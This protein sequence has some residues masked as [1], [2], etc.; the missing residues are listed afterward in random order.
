MLSRMGLEANLPYT[1]NSNSSIYTEF[2]INCAY[3]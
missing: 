1:L 3:A 2:T